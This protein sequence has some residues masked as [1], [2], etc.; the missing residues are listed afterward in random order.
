MFADASAGVAHRVLVHTVVDH[1]N[2]SPGCCTDRMMAVVGPVR[3][4][5]ILQDRHAAAV[6]EHTFAVPHDCTLAVCHSLA[7]GCMAVDHSLVND[8]GNVWAGEE[9]LLLRQDYSCSVHRG[10]VEAE[11]RSIAVPRGI[12][13][14]PPRDTADVLEKD[15]AA[16]KDIAGV[17][18]H[19]NRTT[20]PD[21]RTRPHLLRQS[22]PQD[23]GP[24]L[25]NY[26]D[27]R[28]SKA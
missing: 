4:D 5:H 9:T 25:W 6:A 7:A 14:G 26:T 1:T 22:I 24:P 10:P 3:T 18:T 20:R 28:N 11:A 27:P 13:G 17:P 8:P 23:T 12:A 21:A 15:I 2:R 19:W 16:R